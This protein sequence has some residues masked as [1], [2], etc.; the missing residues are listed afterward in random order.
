MD[1]IPVLGEDNN[2]LDTQEW[3]ENAMEN[4]FVG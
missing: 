3:Y 2:D 4:K 1:D